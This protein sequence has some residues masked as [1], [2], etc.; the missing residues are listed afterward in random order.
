MS[1][2]ELVGGALCGALVG[3]LM[4][5]T[6]IGG[7]VVL[8]PV[9]ILLLGVEPIAAVGAAMVFSV[10]VRFSAIRHHTRLGN[11]DAHVA[12][13]GGV[14][15]APG[16]II[17]ATTL[18]AL[19]ARYPEATNR[20]LQVFIALVIGVSFAL[21][22]L[23]PRRSPQAGASAPAAEAAPARVPGL[24]GFGVLVGV[25]MGT[26]SVG[27]GVFIVPALISWFGLTTARAVGTSIAISTIPAI[28]GAIIYAT[29]GAVAWVQ[30][31]LLLAGSLAGVPL[32]ARAATR[33]PERVL[34]RI[35]LI[36]MG[37]SALL[38]MWPR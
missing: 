16:V 36:V 5:M 32:G 18:L 12:R 29:Q 21:M 34:R 20:A 17:A 7:G 13:W 15:T 11:I 10:A 6:G 3:F 27:G 14:G 2:L 30:V 25:L 31:L 19:N 33:V 8:Q 35:I 1:G 26:T 23:C 37:A 28:V 9:L 24:L 4:G 22:L 38:L